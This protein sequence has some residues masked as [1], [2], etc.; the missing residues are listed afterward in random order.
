VHCACY[1]CRLLPVS[2]TSRARHGL[3]SKDHAICRHWRPRRWVYHIF[4]GVMTQPLI[5][6]RLSVL[7]VTDPSFKILDKDS[8]PTI[9]TATASISR[10]SDSEAHRA[11]AYSLI[12]TLHTKQRTHLA[13]RSMGPRFMET[14]RMVPDQTKDRPPPLPYPGM[15]GPCHP[16]PCMVNFPLHIHQKNMHWCAQGY[17]RNGRL[18]WVS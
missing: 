17:N 13:P 4:V 1:L 12:L 8:L 16:S 14:G 9:P 10:I 15:G 11:I 7:Q 18:T 6:T 3:L 2:T 5:D